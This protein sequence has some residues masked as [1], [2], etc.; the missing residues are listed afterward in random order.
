MALKAKVKMFLL[1][2]IFQTNNPPNICFGIPDIGT[3]YG[4][5]EA[6]DKL[7]D[8]YNLWLPSLFFDP[9]TGLWEKD[10]GSDI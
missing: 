5:Q 6:I 9:Q 10:I 2:W 4:N 3:I 1:R 8:K 7:R